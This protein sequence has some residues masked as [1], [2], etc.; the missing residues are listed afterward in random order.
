MKKSVQITCVLGGSDFRLFQRVV[1]QGIDAHL[2]AFT[3]SKFYTKGNRLVLDFA[4]P[5]LPLLVRRLEEIAEQDGEDFDGQAWGWAS[6][7]QQLD[8]YQAEEISP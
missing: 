4:I 8:E 5:E 6:D 3:E 7:I 1:N 2:E